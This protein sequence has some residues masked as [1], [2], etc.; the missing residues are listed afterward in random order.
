M[1]TLITI[2]S[3]IILAPF[4]AL[5]QTGWVKFNVFPVERYQCKVDGELLSKGTSGVELP[6]GPHRISFYSPRMTVWDTVVQVIPDSVIVLR[7][8]LTASVEY[9]N[10]IRMDRNV[11]YKKS[12]L[13]G[14]P[15][16]ATLGSG[17]AWL[18]AHREFREARS[19][20]E[21]LQASYAG[22]DTPADVVIW[23]ERDVPD[24]IERQDK[25]LQRTYVWGGVTVVS[26]AVLFLMAR[27]AA[28][29]ER[30]VFEDKE[31]L[32]FQGISYIPG[33]NDAVMVSLQYKW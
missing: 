23:R 6:Q 32:R 8:V 19:S 16:L 29:L 18:F 7:K 31:G 12:M 14:L 22:L 1:R 13:V 17:T 11:S 26:G 24:A 30:P 5:A 10:F 4:V 21:E 27:K 3:M 25:G 15:L 2:L 20:V 28:R 9:R 33:R